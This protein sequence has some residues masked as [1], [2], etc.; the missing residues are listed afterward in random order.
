MLRLIAKL[1]VGAGTATTVSGVT[2]GLQ[3]AFVKPSD[4]KIV[5][6]FDTVSTTAA[7]FAI[8]FKATSVMTDYVDEFFDEQ[9]KEYKEFIDSLHDIKR[10]AIK[11]INAKKEE[12]EADAGEE[13]TTESTDTSTTGC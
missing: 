2:Y 6:A 1:L 7:R 5:K 13:A 8:T 9:E 12:D 10:A 11:R 3:K 4:K